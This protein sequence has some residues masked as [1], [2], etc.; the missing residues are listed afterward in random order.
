[1]ART[2]DAWQRACERTPHGVPI[3]LQPEDFGE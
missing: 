2:R 3:A 1:L